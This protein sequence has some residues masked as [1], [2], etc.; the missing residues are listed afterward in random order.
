MSELTRHPGWP[1]LVDFMHDRMRAEQLQVLA[2][3]LVTLDDYR[4][5]CGLLAGMQ[6]VLDGPASLAAMVDTERARRAEESPGAA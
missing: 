2:G 3:K 4:A 5:K 6:A 1:L